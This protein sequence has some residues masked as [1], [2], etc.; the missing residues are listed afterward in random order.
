MASVFT[1]LARSAESDFMVKW[2]LLVKGEFLSKFMVMLAVLWAL[3]ESRL[4]A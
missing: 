1:D 3:M 2:A 4:I